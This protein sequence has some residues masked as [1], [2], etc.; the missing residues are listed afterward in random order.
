[1]NTIVAIPS[2]LEF[3]GKPQSRRDT[4]SGQAWL[5]AAR[6]IARK[7]LGFN[8]TDDEYTFR[9]ALYYALESHVAPRHWHEHGV[10]RADNGCNL[11]LAAFSGV[12]YH[13]PVQ[14]TRLE[15]QV[16]VQTRAVLNS[17]GVTRVSWERL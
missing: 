1:M 4:P 17:N 3:P 6:A 15:V 7:T 5:D 2:T 13:H 8:A 12:L 9:V 14:V 10:S 16:F 11:V